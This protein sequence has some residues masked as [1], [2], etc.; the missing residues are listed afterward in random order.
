MPNV[1][2]PRDLVSR[3]DNMDETV[4]HVHTQFLS[5]VYSASAVIRLPSSTVTTCIGGGLLFS[6][7]VIM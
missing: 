2:S 6:Q 3:S 1:L 7:P 4:L 5:F